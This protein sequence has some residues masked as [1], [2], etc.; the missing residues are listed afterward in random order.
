MSFQD[1]KTFFPYYYRCEHL[2]TII[3]ILFYTGNKELRTWC[4]LCL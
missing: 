4:K 1:R 2:R 3:Q